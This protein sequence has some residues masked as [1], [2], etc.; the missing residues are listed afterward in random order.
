MV[1]RKVVRLRRLSFFYPF[2]SLSLISFYEHVRL[3]KRW[4]L[5]LMSLWV[6]HAWGA[7]PSSLR[8]FPEGHYLTIYFMYEQACFAYFWQIL[9]YKTGFRTPNTQV[10]VGKVVNS[11]KGWVR[12]ERKSERQKERGVGSGGWSPLKIYKCSADKPGGPLNYRRNVRGRTARGVD[13]VNSFLAA[14][15][16]CLGVPVRFYE[17]ACVCILWRPL[18]LRFL[19]FSSSEETFGWTLSHQ[20]QKH[21]FWRTLAPPCN[22]KNTYIC[23]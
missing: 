15:R 2:Q 5:L 22:Q 20:L 1:H 19:S 11:L 13:A 16:E 10:A 8:R 9:N 7:F 6:T 14:S 3:T 23:F 17:T 12:R 4:R 18:C 21:D